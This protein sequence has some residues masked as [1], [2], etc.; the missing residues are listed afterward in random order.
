MHVAPRLADRR[1]ARLHPDGVPFLRPNFKCFRLAPEAKISGKR[2]SWAA[3]TSS[4]CTGGHGG[5]ALSLRRKSPRR[6]KSALSS[7]GF[8]ATSELFRRRHHEYDA[9][10]TLEVHG[11]WLAG[12]SILLADHDQCVVKAKIAA[13]TFRLM[14]PPLGK[15]WP[16]SGLTGKRTLPNNLKSDG[17]ILRIGI[18]FHF[19]ALTQLRIARTKKVSPGFVFNTP[20]FRLPA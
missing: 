15:W 10:E 2:A 5:S 9:A 3:C 6:P 20:M 19:C 1:A 18:H 8:N 12:Y 14:L 11:G 17:T 7:R 4:N 16:S 13:E